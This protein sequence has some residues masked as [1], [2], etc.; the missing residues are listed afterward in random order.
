MGDT[1]FISSRCQ[2]KS[3][4]EQHGDCAIMITDEFETMYF[5]RIL[6][7]IH[8]GYNWEVFA[9]N[10]MKYEKYRHL[11]IH[12]LEISDTTKQE[13]TLLCQNGAEVNDHDEDNRNSLHS[14]AEDG[15]TEL[16]LMLMEHNADVNFQ[17]NNGMT[18]IFLA[19]GGNHLEAVNCYG[20]I[21]L[22]LRNVTKRMD[23]IH[24]ASNANYTDIV[25][26]I[27]D[28]SAAVVNL[29]NNKGQSPL[30]LACKKGHKDT[31][32]PM[33]IKNIAEIL[34]KEGAAV[35]KVNVTGIPALLLAYSN[36][37]I[38]IAKLLLDNGAEVN[39]RD[40]YGQTPLYKAAVDDNTDFIKFLFEHN[41]DIMNLNTNSGITP[42]MQLVQLDN[43]ERNEDVD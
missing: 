29:S 5:E 34:I 10:Q 22:T 43:L 40:E 21:N 4:N 35:N 16:I 26:Y 7:D 32:V 36:K 12:C 37:Q 39:S 42:V 33:V 9:N 41:A 25:K 2:L 38:E 27:C 3:L 31:L 18:S 20:V 13:I 24:I 19:C 28:H 1:A 8:M 14:A 11:L 23:T 6:K 17:M 30:H 15:N